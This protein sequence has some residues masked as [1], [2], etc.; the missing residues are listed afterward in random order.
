MRGIERTLIIVKPDGVAR[1]LIGE[2]IM[3][4]EQRGLKLV[5]MKMVW[6]EM[7]FAERHYKKDIEERH[8]KEVR[9]RLLKY[10][11]EGPVVAFAVEGIEAVKIA[12]KI[13]GETYPDRAAV[14]TIR[15]DYAHVSK[16]YAISNDRDVKNLVHASGTKEE[17]ESEIALWFAENELHSYR[18]C[19]EGHVF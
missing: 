10:I 16:E 5:G 17:A 4:F 6:P 15:G 19:H 2:I 11:I 7:K 18:T 3:R 14:G 9:E 8:G 1:G 13:C 12:R